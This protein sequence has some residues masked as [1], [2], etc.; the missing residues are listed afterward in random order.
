MYSGKIAVPPVGG[1]IQE[2]WWNWV[3][4]Y[5]AQNKRKIDCLIFEVYA[6]FLHSSVTGV[7]FLIYRR[8]RR[9]E[10]DCER[11]TGLQLWSADLL[12]KSHL[13][14]CRV[15]VYSLQ[16]EK[17]VFLR[18]VVHLPT[19][20]PIKKKIPFIVDR[21]CWWKYKKNNILEY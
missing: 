13:T 8:S 1:G 3:Y 15:C 10:V 6:I 11:T 2:K 21:N 17:S 5:K 12:I 16:F 9:W 20:T 18:R 4:I 19:S 14:F 7:F